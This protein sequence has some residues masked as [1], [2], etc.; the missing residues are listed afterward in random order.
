MTTKQNTLYR[1]LVADHSLRVTTPL[2][3]SRL[4]V[5]RR[6]DGPGR[7]YVVLRGD[8]GRRVVAVR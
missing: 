5:E 8:H 1:A 6:H 2:D 4:A 3:T 7:P